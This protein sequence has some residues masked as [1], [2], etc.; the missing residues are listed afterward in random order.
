MSWASTLATG[1]GELSYRLEIERLEEQFVTHASMATA[2]RFPWLSVRGGKLRCS[3]NPITGDLDVSGLQARIID[4]QGGATAIF[5][6]PPPNVTWLTA[7]VSPTAVTIPVRSTTGWPSSGYLWLDSE[8]IAYASLGGGGTSFD[9]C[10]RGAL[11]SLA[12]THYVNVGASQRYPE[13]TSSIVSIAGCRARLYV[14]GQTDDPQGDG[15]L[16]WIGVVTRHPTL[17]GPT[18][19]IPIDPVTSVL[20]R[21]LAS[22]LEEPTTARGIKYDWSNRFNITFQR[23]SNFDTLSVVAPQTGTYAVGGFFESN[24]EFANALNPIIA[25]QIVAQGWDAFGCSIRIIPTPNSYMIGITQ[26]GSELVDVNYQAQTDIDPVFAAKPTDIDGAAVASY[27]SGVEYYWRP[28]TASL[29]GA[30]S[31]PRGFLG[32]SDVGV[33]GAVSLADLY[34]V[35]ELFIAG[36]E[37][38]SSVDTLSIEWMEHGRFPKSETTPLVLDSDPVAN[39]LF[40]DESFA[41]D[42]GVLPGRAHAWTAA[43]APKIRLGRTYT[44]SGNIFT[45]LVRIIG[46]APT[47]LN[48]G[49]VPD[50][51]AGDLGDGWNAIDGSEQP[52]IVRARRFTSFNEVSL[53]EVVRHEL[54]LAGFMLGTDNTGKITIAPIRAPAQT[55]LPDVTIDSVLVSD[56]LPVWEPSAYGM[57]NQVAFSRGY[58]ALEDDYTV[59]RV[60]VR[61]VA[62]FGRNPTPRT[63]K[64]EPKSVPA[65]GVETQDEVLEV[66]QRL[67]AA[68]SGPYAVIRVDV[69]LTAFTNAT[70]GAVVALTSRHIPDPDTGT[71]GVT[72][73]RC[74]VTGREVNLDTGAVSLR[75]YT[76]TSPIAGYAPEALILSEVNTSGNI[77]AL[78]LDPQYFPSGT[79][80]ADWFL[81]G[82]VVRVRLWDST[83]ATTQDGTVTAAA[84]NVV[85]VSFAGAVA[86]GAG[87]WFL[88]FEQSNATL[89]ASQYAFAFLGSSDMKVTK[90]AAEEPARRFA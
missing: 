6:G 3:S 4:P 50:L 15:S 8:C 52:R 17:A 62:E 18:W 49:S 68:Y 69:P 23:Q 40:L 65:A 42:A 20:N 70:I 13:V 27:S 44:E 1:R 47:L 58:S 9:G 43:S 79:T 33:G 83:T 80:A 46:L 77:W 53:M 21:S 74:I 86:L 90:G 88:T 51:R 87:E 5:S 16:I 55:E 11:S 82:H 59:G 37:V 61:N 7:E 71:M 84:S 36:A 2:T 38:G 64:I 56:S 14:Y 81:V 25:A 89:A 32:Y 39:S 73:R 19:S 45:A 54:L 30:G 31:V 72:A 75:L 78:T 28:T 22:D 57:V 10:T 29:A 34:P 26:D 12:Q 66:A 63:A 60:T 24:E 67:F 85:T 41:P 76:S 35:N 48:A